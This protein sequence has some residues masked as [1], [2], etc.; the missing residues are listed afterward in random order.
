MN[1]QTIHEMNLHDALSIE[2]RP[3]MLAAGHV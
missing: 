1:L 2:Q 3:P